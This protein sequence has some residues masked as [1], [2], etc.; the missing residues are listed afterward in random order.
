MNIF[1]TGYLDSIASGLVEELSKEKGNKIILAGKNAGNFSDKSKKI[2]THSVDLTDPFLGDIINSYDLDALIFIPIR[3]EQ[4]LTGEK[5]SSG[6][7]LDGLINILGLCKNKS[8]LWFILLSSTEVEDANDLNRNSVDNLLQDTFINKN[9]LQACEQYCMYFNHFY[10]LHTSIIRVP[11]LYGPQETN[12]LLNKLIVDC[13]N[14]SSV[15]FPSNRDS[16]CNFL[17]VKDLSD[18]IRRLLDEEYH[19]NY[20]MFTLSSPDV[21]SF[22]EIQKYLHKHFPKVKFTY[23]DN[24]QLYTKPVEESLAIKEFDWFTMHK[25]KEELEGITKTIQEKPSPKITVLDSIKSKL[26]RFPNLMK[27]IELILGGAFMQLMVYLTGTFVQFKYIDFRLLYVI[28]IGSVHGLKFALLASIVAGISNLFSWYQL[29]LDW[30]L[31]IY[32]V[33]NWFPFALYLIAGSITGY[34]WDK[35]ENEINFTNDQI[36]LIQEKYSFLYNIFEDIRGTKDQ[37]RE[38]LIGSRDSFGRIYTIT[39]E[40]DSL[41]SNDVFLKALDILE[42]VMDNKS[43][44]I[45]ALDKTAQY[46]RLE[47]NS[48]PLKNNTSKTLKVSDFP[49]A[50]DSITR[51]EIFQNQALTP[52][53]PSLIAPIMKDDVLFGMIFIWERRFDQFSIYYQNLFKIVSGLIESSLIRATLFK[54]IN[55]D[56]WYLPSTRILIP[57]MFK[58][59]LRIKAEMQ[60]KNITAFQLLE[61]TKGEMEWKHFSKILEKGIRASDY[62]GLLNKD[63]LHCY[64]ILSQAEQT[65]VKMVVTRLK[66]MGLECKVVESS[67][68]TYV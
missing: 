50:I 41:N 67:K 68:I 9:V 65:N 32:H 42:D 55:S 39:Q 23:Q 51:G 53:Y 35:K 24:M 2:I 28:L 45:Y 22:K 25:F 49:L 54:D 60:S 38:Q 33:E 40:L 11:F 6:F 5:F 30:E 27:W 3:E 62:A 36:K 29:G 37:L 59:T 1:I 18:F 15:A 58:E 56:K 63:D 4:L 17:H 10:H 52:G 61:V 7:Y 34:A 44:A 47:V 20:E 13:V 19:H 43:I 48:I 16:V 8:N 26:S 66:K 57:D 46:A 31:L 14:S 64:V 12:S 21:I